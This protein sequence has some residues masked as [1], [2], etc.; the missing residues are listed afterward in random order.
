MQACRRES[1][2][3]VFPCARPFST[4]GGAPRSSGDERKRRREEE[5]L[6]WLT[7]TDD[8]PKKQVKHK[9]R[10]QGSAVN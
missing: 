8:E 2:G 9:C 3:V 7:E 10:L 1:S 6:K 4:E 5:D